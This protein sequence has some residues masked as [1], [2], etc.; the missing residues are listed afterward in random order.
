[1]PNAPRTRRLSTVLFLD[2][3]GSTAVAAELGD[4][5]WRELLGRFQ[6]TVR[7]ELR[8]FGGHEEDTAGDGVFAIPSARCAHGFC[9]SRG[10]VRATTLMLP[11]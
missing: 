7:T 3:V 4:A 2:I 10:L 5:R 1:M 6:R 8:R 11:E 9:L